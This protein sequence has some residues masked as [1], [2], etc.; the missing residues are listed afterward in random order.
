MTDDIP[1]EKRSGWRQWAEKEF[2][3]NDAA[4]EIATETVL[5]ALVQGYSPSE[6]MDAAR[7]AAGGRDQGPTELEQPNLLQHPTSD[8]TH[9]RGVVG[10]FRE[11]SELM[12]ARYGAVWNF[13]VDHWDRDQKLEQPVAVEMRGITFAGSIGD[14]DWVEIEGDWKPGD[15]LR[16]SS[17]QN[18]SQNA[19]V[20]AK[21][22][23]RSN[24]VGCLFLLIGLVVLVVVVY[25]FLQG[26]MS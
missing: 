7:T 6:A 15:I 17:L 3:G 14:G 16:V 24:S 12:G 22:A 4:V 21:G 9:L 8:R 19:T 23:P 11:R 2:P 25:L 1:A 13:R 26:G 20:V 5:E 10:S 18:I